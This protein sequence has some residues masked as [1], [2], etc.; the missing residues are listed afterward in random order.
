[1]DHRNFAGSSNDSDFEDSL[2]R[3]L[4]MEEQQHR[5]VILGGG[6]S[7]VG[8]AL[9]AQKQGAKVFL[10][11][12]GQIG[13]NQRVELELAG[14]DFESG[15]HTWEKIFAADEVIKSP[16]IPDTVPLIQQLR[17][18]DV[19]V[20]GEIEYAARFTD[21]TLIGITGSNGKTTTAYLVHHLLEAAG[22]DVALVGN[23]GFGFARHLAQEEE[24][25][26][27]VIEI[28]S[29]QLDSIVHFRSR[30]STILNIT[31]DHLDRYN[32]EMDGYIDSKLRITR[33]Q[34]EDDQ[35]FYLAGDPNIAKGM[36]RNAVCAKKF[37]INRED[38]DGKN[39]T[40]GDLQ[41]DL[42]NTQLRGKH[43]ALNALFAAGMTQAIGLSAA[44]VKSGLKSFEPVPH[45]LEPVGTVDD[46][47][48]INDSKATNVDAVTYALDAMEKD[49][50]WIAGGTDKGNDYSPLYDLV[51]QK[52]KVLICMGVDNTKLK[53][54]FGDRIE[55]IQEAKSAQEAVQLAKEAAQPGQVVLL[56]PAC[57]SF[58]LFKNYI[59]RGNQ[60]RTAVQQLF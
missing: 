21:A 22:K 44:E 51:Q 20:I 58:D 53:A 10:S 57:A 6:E 46:V 7:G 55:N 50:I 5:I 47:Q 15:K 49:I 25:D 56:S 12:R 29:F 30:Y 24:P 16:G 38:I 26:Y 36:K 1:M 4:G 41:I 14:I 39:I 23:V 27:F 34:L 17:D 9:L 59:D 40:V 52:V 11:D 32:Y 13:E 42:S 19:P 2:A 48:Y 37:A 18:Q 3:T 31:P 43:N 8:A 45:R 28:S 54:A 60:F 35:F 33:N